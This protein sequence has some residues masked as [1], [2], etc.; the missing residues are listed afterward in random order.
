V[1]T[2]INY[3]EVY[4]DNALKNVLCI[5]CTTDVHN[6]KDYYKMRSAVAGQQNEQTV[7]VWPK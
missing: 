7:K 3:N 4:V 5:T 1:E 2:A 6:V